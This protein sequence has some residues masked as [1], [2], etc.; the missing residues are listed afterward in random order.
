MERMFHLAIVKKINT[1]KGNRRILLAVKKINI[2][3]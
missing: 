1:I 3:K 2:F